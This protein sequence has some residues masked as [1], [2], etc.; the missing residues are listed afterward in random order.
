MTSAEWDRPVA[1]AW[2]VPL[3]SLPRL[4]TQPPDPFAEGAGGAWE[5]EVTG[6]G[7]QLK[8]AHWVGWEAAVVEGIT[9]CVGI[10]ANSFPFLSKY[11]TRDLVQWPCSMLL[12]L[13]VGFCARPPP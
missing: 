8:S 10:L 2:Q 12:D 13:G 1:P 3:F 9:G 5:A 7:R 11:R 6:L 4:S